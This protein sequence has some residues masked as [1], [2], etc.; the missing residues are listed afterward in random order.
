MST[1]DYPL[2]T[3]TDW[4]G[5]Y[6]FLPPGEHGIFSQTYDQPGNSQSQTQPRSAATD[7]NLD[8]E[9]KVEAH[10]PHDHRRSLDPLGLRQQKQPSPI[11]EQVEPQGDDYAQKAAETV[12]DESLLS[13][14]AS[15]MSVDSNPLNSISSGGQAPETGASQGGN[16]VDL[17]PKDEDDDV[18]DDEDM[19]E[20][21][22]VAP[23][24][25]TAAERTAARRKMK[26]F[27]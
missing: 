20:E 27:R 10:S 11:P 12:Q 14:G 22:D 17:I 23:Q 1:S 6:S 9:V 24:P 16:E 18:I 15:G 25:Q 8:I 5:S 2:S 7:S 19:L 26:R 4:Q 13:T 21:G 3:G